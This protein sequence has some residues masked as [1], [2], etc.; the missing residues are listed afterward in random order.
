M[1]IRDGYWPPRMHDVLETEDAM[2]QQQEP[3]A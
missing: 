1:C 3:Q 2:M